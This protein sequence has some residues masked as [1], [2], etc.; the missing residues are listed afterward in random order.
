MRWRKQR[1]FE[2][3]I[4][5]RN[6][7]F[8]NESIRVR[9]PFTPTISSCTVYI[10]VGYSECQRSACVTSGG[11]SA[12]Y[13]QSAKYCNSFSLRKGC[14]AWCDSASSDSD[15]CDSV[16]RRPSLRFPLSFKRLALKAGTAS[17]CSLSR[18]SSSSNLSCS[19]Y[20]PL[21]LVASA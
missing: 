13:L 19:K 21:S 12:V 4:R 7:A 20:E 2:R 8:G 10:L 18:P 17:S 1:K 9:P 6:H 15:S 5:K 14:E 11:Q 16:S 3:R